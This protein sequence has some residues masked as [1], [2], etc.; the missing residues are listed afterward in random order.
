M[1]DATIKNLTL[2]NV[3]VNVTAGS[4][5]GALVGYARNNT[6]ISY[7]SV[8]SGSVRGVLM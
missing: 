2:S 8:T 5:T 4:Y 3:N 1:E 6:T 7:V